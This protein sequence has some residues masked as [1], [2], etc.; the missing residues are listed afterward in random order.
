MPVSPSPAPDSTR[1]VASTTCSRTNSTHSTH[2]RTG[3]TDSDAGLGPD[4]K[5]LAKAG[6]YAR[7][8]VRRINPGK[9]DLSLT[10]QG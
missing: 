3:R 4:Q 6:P 5:I 10:P 7:S 1:P 9:Q 8:D 2:S